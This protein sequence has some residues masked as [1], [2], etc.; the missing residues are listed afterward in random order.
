MLLT[1]GCVEVSPARIPNRLLEGAGGN[2]WAVNQTASQDEPTGS[3]FSKAQSLVYEDRRSEEG[4]PGTLTVSTL[5]ALMRPREEAVRDTVQERIREEAESRGVTIQGSA[6]TGERRLGNG[7]DSLWFVYN[8]SVS[9][10]GFFSARDARV[11]IYGEVFE[12]GKAIVVV[13]GLAQTTD[14]RSVGGVP[15]PSEADPTT[16]REIASDPRGS[17][18]G[19]RGSDGLAYNVQC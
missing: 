11:K 4:Y 16:W 13:V 10:A 19:I 8:G 5:R 17:I 14:V 12:C 2:G 1:A 6:V 7:A 18:E 9:S 15:L 3:S